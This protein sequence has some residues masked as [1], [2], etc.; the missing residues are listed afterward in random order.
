MESPK[1][2]ERDGREKPLTIRRISDT[3]PR[4]IRIKLA[5]TSDKETI[6][7]VA[8]EKWHSMYRGTKIKMRVDFSLKQWK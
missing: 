2:I 4:H 3:T 1:R 6:L 8:R 7:K 5:K